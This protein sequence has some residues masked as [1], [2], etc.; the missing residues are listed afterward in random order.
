MVQ[1]MNMVENLFLWTGNYQ[2]EFRHPQQILLSMIFPAVMSAV[3]SAL[4][5][6]SRRYGEDCL[7][8]LVFVEA[9]G[10]RT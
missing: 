10:C 1:C 3:V 2:E 8:K 6:E 5:S 9:F 4:R 7:K